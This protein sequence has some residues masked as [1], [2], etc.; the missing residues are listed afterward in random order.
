MGLWFSVFALVVSLGTSIMNYKSNWGLFAICCF[1]V[2]LNA[3]AITL[4]L[5]KPFCVQ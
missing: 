5:I 2:G 4:H 1:A 3:V